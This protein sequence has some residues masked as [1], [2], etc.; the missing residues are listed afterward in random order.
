MF[1]PEALT[2]P[3]ISVIIAVQH[4]LLHLSDFVL[5][6]C[7]LVFASFTGQLQHRTWLQLTWQQQKDCLSL[8]G[9]GWQRVTSSLAL[10]VGSVTA[11][12][13]RNLA[14]IVQMRNELLV[15]PVP[16]CLLAKTAASVLEKILLVILSVTPLVMLFAPLYRAATG[17]TWAQVWK[18]EGLS[19]SGS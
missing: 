9:R 8:V 5:E 2:P 16:R 10:A 3:W 18:V 11:V 13:S 1:S 12:E 15:L 14:Q 4:A 7:A 17:S 6:K 19:S